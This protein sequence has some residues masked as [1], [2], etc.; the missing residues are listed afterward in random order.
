MSPLESLP[1][2]QRPFSAIKERTFAW[3][4]W[5]AS[6]GLFAFGLRTM[7]STARDSP[8]VEAVIAASVT[9]MQILSLVR[10]RQYGTMK[11]FVLLALTG[12]WAAS[13]AANQFG[14][15]PA[16]A[17]GAITAAY[18]GAM[19]YVGSKPGEAASR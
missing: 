5:V 8:G 4:V 16:A 12:V 6:L 10:F 13:F 17:H 19:F 2:W 9:L 3:S 7:F 15:L 11:Y 1:F 14:Y 18:V